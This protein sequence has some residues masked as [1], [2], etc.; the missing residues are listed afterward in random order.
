M[1]RSHDL[2]RGA[3]SLYQTQTASDTRYANVSGDTFT[4]NVNFN[5]GTITHNANSEASNKYFALNTGASND[6]HLLFQ[7]AGSNKFQISSD[8]A[9]NLFTWNY[10]KNG[11]SHRINADGSVITPHQPG[12]YAVGSASYVNR[13]VGVAIEYSSTV[14][15]NGNCYST[16]TYKFTAPHAGMYHFSAAAIAHS[17]STGS[18]GIMIT[19]NGSNKARSYQEGGSRSRNCSVTLDLAASDFVDVRIE[20]SDYYYLSGGY[21][22]FSGYMIG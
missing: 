6:G 20:G 18:G 12:F 1:G 3:S 22:Y 10:T 11:T 19:Q 14:F 8:T 7:R 21:G 17:A 9:N 15:N 13:G 4:G 5:S 16:S 2:A